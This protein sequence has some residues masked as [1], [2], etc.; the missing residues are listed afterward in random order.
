MKRRLFFLLAALWVAIAVA[1]ADVRQ[2]FALE[3]IKETRKKSLAHQQGPNSGPQVNDSRQDSQIF[4]RPWRSESSHD[5]IVTI[6]DT[7]S[8]TAS[9]SAH[10]AALSIAPR[11]RRRSN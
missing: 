6:P 10:E 4:S 2:R 7:C 1:G 8:A 11:R 3:S 9:L 5:R